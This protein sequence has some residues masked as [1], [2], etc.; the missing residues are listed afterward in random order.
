MNDERMISK[1]ELLAATGISYGQFY[2]WKRMGL[3]PEQ[4]FQRRSTRTGH[5]T[6]L[7]RGRILERIAEIQAL[8]DGRSLEEIAD[9]FAAGG[10]T[11]G[12]ADGDLEAGGLIS[13]RARRLYE[14]IRRSAGRY[15]FIELVCMSLIDRLLARSTVSGDQ[16]VLAARALGQADADWGALNGRA[17]VLLLSR[18]GV[19][20]A[21]VATGQCTFGPDAE[22]LVAVDVEPIAQDVRRKLKDIESSNTEGHDR[23]AAK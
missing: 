9:V 19:V 16:A 13:E 2:R 18:F 17:R 5:E 7:P 22:M 20:I 15:E 4:W 8:K 12:L 10:R 6:Y 21:A 14:P 1:K 11:H 23:D 3:I